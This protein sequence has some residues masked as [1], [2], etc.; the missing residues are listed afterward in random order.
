MPAPMGGSLPQCACSCPNG[1]FCAHAPASQTDD[2]GFLAQCAYPAGR[3]PRRASLA[4]CC[5][6]WRLKE[7]RAHHWALKTDLQ[8][9]ELVANPLIRMLK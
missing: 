1:R 6:H 2:G 9:G 4:N 3:A 7:P 5:C 8:P